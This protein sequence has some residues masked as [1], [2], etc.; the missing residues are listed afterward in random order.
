MA[1]AQQMGSQQN[2]TNFAIAHIKQNHRYN[3]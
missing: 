1:A 2:V 3:L